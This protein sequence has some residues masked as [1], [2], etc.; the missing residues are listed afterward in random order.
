M[1][2]ENVE[3]YLACIYDLS[4]NGEIVKTTQIASRLSIAPASVTEMIKKLDTQ[5]YVVYEQYKGVK[6]TEEGLNLARRVKR[7]HRLLERFFVD[8]LGMKKEDSHDEAMRLE[9]TVSDESIERISKILNDPQTCPGG[10]PIPPPDV[11]QPEVKGISVQLDALEQGETASVTHIASE[12]LER[13]HRLISMGIVPGHNIS[14]EEKV[15]VGGPLLIKIGGRRI[16]LAKD[17]SS[18]VWVRRGPD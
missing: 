14:I 9:H 5:G 8:I 2:S 10:S 11:P 6:L 12:D 3:D 17:M 18:L 1:I 15:P 13:V 16:A 4:R 7:R